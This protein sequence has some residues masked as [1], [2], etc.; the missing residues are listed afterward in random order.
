MKCDRPTHAAAVLMSIFWSRAHVNC[1]YVSSNHAQVC[2]WCFCLCFC[3]LRCF[4][5]LYFVLPLSHILKNIVNP[6]HAECMYMCAK[7]GR[8]TKTPCL[9]INAAII[10]ITFVRLVAIFFFILFYFFIFFVLLFFFSAFYWLFT[11][12]ESHFFGEPSRIL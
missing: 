4:F 12:N 10:F 3:R 9:L 2:Y 7:S 5:F 1:K 8:V 11:L 6:L